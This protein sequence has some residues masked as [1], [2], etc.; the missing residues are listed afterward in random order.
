[1][2]EE[3]KR[4]KII[5]RTEYEVT[6]DTAVELPEGIVENDVESISVKWGR[7]YLSLKDGGEISVDLHEDFLNFAENAKRPDECSVMSVKEHIED[8]GFDN[9]ELLPVADAENGDVTETPNP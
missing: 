7:A 2:S 3:N 4:E 9:V 1:M 5:V 6:F 8:M